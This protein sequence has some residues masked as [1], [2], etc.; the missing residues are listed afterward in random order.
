VVYSLL[1][2]ELRQR[3]CIEILLRSGLGRR[4]EVQGLWLP[5]NPGVKTGKYAVV[6]AARRGVVM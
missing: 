5:Q 6:V 1:L 4:C 3:E 2:D